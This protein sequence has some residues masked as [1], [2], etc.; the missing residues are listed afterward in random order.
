MAD[1]LSIPS[2]LTVIYFISVIMCSRHRGG[3]K[4]Y[5]GD[6]DEGE[7]AEVE[8]TIKKV[9]KRRKRQDSLHLIQALRT[10]LRSRRL[11]AVKYCSIFAT[12]VLPASPS[13]PFLRHK[14]DQ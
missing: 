10:Y 14:T 13:S 3:R 9:M 2:N 5:K 12:E 7:S 4:D 1:T 8:E 11:R 6:N